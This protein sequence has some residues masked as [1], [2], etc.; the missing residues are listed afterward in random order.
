MPPIVFSPLV[1]LALG[2]L[3]TGIIVRWV[4]KEA[5]R[6]NADLDRMRA[7]TD[8][9]VRRTL[10]TLRRDAQISARLNFKEV[11]RCPEDTLNQIIW[12]AMKGPS[13]PYPLWAISSVEDHD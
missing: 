4:V 13:E 12:R 9:S 1:R 10:P 2:A 7:P 3:G 5:R 8:P 6:I 11:D